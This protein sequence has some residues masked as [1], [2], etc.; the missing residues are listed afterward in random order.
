MVSF[1]QESEVYWGEC[2]ASRASCG[3]AENPLSYYLHAREG[4]DF[5]LHQEVALKHIRAIH[6]HQGED[7]P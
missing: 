3:I 1:G 5:R 4:H 6:I 2:T 7:L